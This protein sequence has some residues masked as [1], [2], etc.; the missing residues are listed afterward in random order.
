MISNV[1]RG[2]PAGRRAYAA[3]SL[4]AVAIMT[5]RAVAVVAAVLVA[6]AMRLTVAQAA[7]GTNWRSSASFRKP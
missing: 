7:R 2:R 1:G 3:I 6:D 5:R 4:Y